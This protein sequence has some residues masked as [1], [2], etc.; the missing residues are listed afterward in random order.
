MNCAVIFV[1]FYL[2]FHNLLRKLQLFCCFFVNILLVIADI[3]E[4]WCELFSVWPWSF[5]GGQR[6]CRVSM[7]KSITSP[8]FSLPVTKDETVKGLEFFGNVNISYLPENVAEVFPNLVGYGAGNCSIKSIRKANFE[9]LTNL[10]ELLLFENFIETIP[11]NIFDNLTSLEFINLGKK[12]III[13][14]IGGVIT[15]FTFM[16]HIFRFQQN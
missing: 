16:I 1:Q 6:T 8:G 14:F 2:I 9:G 11:N 4:T 12:N 7:T 3:D 5:S 13:H 15:E 10:K